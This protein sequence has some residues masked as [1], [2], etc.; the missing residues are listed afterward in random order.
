MNLSALT[1]NW[2]TTLTSVG[3]ALFSALTILAALPAQLGELSTVL[4]EEWKPP[5]IKVGIVAT[6]LLR[7][8]NGMMTKD[9][10]VTGNG[11]LDTPAFKPDRRNINT[12]AGLLVLL[13]GMTLALA[14]CTTDAQGRRQ[15]D[16][17]ALLH[18][19]ELTNGL[20]NRVKPTPAPK[21]LQ[22]VP[23]PV[24]SAEA[25]NP[26]ARTLYHQGAVIVPALAE[27]PLVYVNGQLT[28]AL[29]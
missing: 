4:P 21:P 3:A 2:R 5:V 1:A 13:A 15:I 14:G 16:T 7:I 26:A 25:T 20:L 6:I 23:E 8:L 11:S 17:D 19:A 24:P 9:A 28:P 10:V 12:G 29:P 18:A 27:A 22:L